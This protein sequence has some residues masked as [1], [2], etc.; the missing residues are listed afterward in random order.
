MRSIGYVVC[1][2]WP[3]L[4][5]SIITNVDYLNYIWRYIY[6]SIY[7]AVQEEEM[8]RVDLNKKK[9]PHGLPLFLRVDM[10]H[11]FSKKE[12]SNLKKKFSLYFILFYIET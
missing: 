6:I 4:L 9:V 2:E 11:N 10:Y 5:A 1:A 3:Y 8:E 12:L 7:L